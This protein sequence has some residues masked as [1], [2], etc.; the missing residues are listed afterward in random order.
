MTLSI[1]SFSD[2]LRND[3]LDHFDTFEE[4][5]DFDAFKSDTF[6]NDTFESEWIDRHPLNVGSNSVVQFRV[7]DSWRV[8]CLVLGDQKVSKFR[9]SIFGPDCGQFLA[10]QVGRSGFLM[11]SNAFEQTWVCWNLK[12]ELSKF[13]AVQNLLYLGS[14]QHYCQPGSIFD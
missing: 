14:N 5:F 8:C 13:K 7:L 2:I 6:E 4:N 3:Y 1:V 11:G 12:L 10:Q 9:F